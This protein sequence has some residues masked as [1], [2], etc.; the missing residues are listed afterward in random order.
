VRPGGLVVVRPLALALLAA[1]A[2]APNLPLRPDPAPPAGS[3][4]EVITALD[5]TQLL[6]RHWAA[7]DE[8]AVVVIMHGLRD[9][10]AR[11]AELATMLVAHGYTVYAFDLRGHGRSAGPRVAP[12]DW[13]DYVGDLDRVLTLIEQREPGKPVFLFGHSMGGEIAGLAA[14]RHR[15]QLAGLILSGPALEVAAP[16]LLIPG[17]R[18]AAFLLPGAPGLAF[19]NRDFSSDPETGPAMDADPLI[20]SAIAPAHTAAGLIEGI[21]AFWDGLD[22]LTMPILALHGTADRLT[23]PAGSRM[24]I[25][26]APSHDKTLKIYPGL[27]HD[28]VH[29]PKGAQVRDDIIAWLDAHTGGAALPATPMYRGELVG[30]P[31]GW[32]QAIELAGGVA[33]G[34]I[35]GSSAGFA[36]DIA[37]NIARPEPF[38]WHAALDAW[39]ANRSYAIALRPLGIAVTRRAVAIG[40]S[41][42]LALV[43][44][45]PLEDTGLDDGLRFAYSGALWFEIPLGPLHFS[46]RAEFDRE[47]KADR[48]LIVALSSVRIGRD[49]Q[50][51]PGAHGG[52]GPTLS[53]GLEFNG[54]STAFVALIG[55]QLFGTN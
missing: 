38:G 33:D 9:Y 27:F 39:T 12:D 36:G 23:A 10:S 16:A 34:S 22:A 37:I 13:F 14:E 25:E 55:L 41:A 6:A 44:Y 7:P 28:L 53:G 26:R 54:Y 40:I 51:W 32:T 30:D 45:G 31:K 50:Y 21:H 42:G 35:A 24:L 15:P 29:E 47:L 17:T 11:Y 18:M 48:G 1:C 8:K 4:T 19:D 46:E 3:T 2:S 49:R 52:V 20:S 43:H 5:G